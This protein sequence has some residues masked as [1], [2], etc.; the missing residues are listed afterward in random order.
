MRTLRVS[1]GGAGDWG[2]EGGQGGREAHASE[3]DGPRSA[4]LPESSC[5]AKA[6]CRSAAPH[7]LAPPV[8]HIYTHILVTQHTVKAAWTLTFPLVWVGLFSKGKCTIYEGKCEP[9]GYQARYQ[10]LRPWCSRRARHLLRM[11]SGACREQSCNEAGGRNRRE[12]SPSLRP[13]E[14]NATSQRLS[15]TYSRKPLTKSPSQIPPG[16]YDFAYTGNPDAEIPAFRDDFSAKYGLFG[17]DFESSSAGLVSSGYGGWALT[18]AAHPD[19][20]TGIHGS[21]ITAILSAVACILTS[22]AYYR[23]N[24][25]QSDIS[26]FILGRC[27]WLAAI[28]L[29]LNLTT[30]GLWGILA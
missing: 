10:S 26:V 20:F 18:N 25:A 5:R 2:R 14:P 22:M 4:R 30:L 3:R 23:S 19:A 8:A 6:L 17:V 16:W 12:R 24:K 13:S 1:C 15:Y 11:C 7:S 29:A 27:S 28:D 21:R 9:R